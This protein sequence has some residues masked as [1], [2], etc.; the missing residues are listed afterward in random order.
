MLCILFNVQHVFIYIIIL[1][2]NSI[3]LQKNRMSLLRSALRLTPRSRSLPAAQPAAEYHDKVS[4]L[5][6][7]CAGA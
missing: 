2:K 1:V 3:L 4:R 7:H 6:G 5:V